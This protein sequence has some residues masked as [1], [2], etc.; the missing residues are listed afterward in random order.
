M[1]TSISSTDPPSVFAFASHDGHVRVTSAAELLQVGRIGKPHG[2]KGLVHVDLSTDRIE[3]LAVGTRLL[4]GDEWLTVASA[5]RHGTAWLVR[6]EGIDD[7]TA[8]E[9]IASRILRAEPIDDPDA[10]WVHELVGAPVRERD[11]TGRGR[12]VA[13]IANPAHDLLELD[14]GALV[15]VAFVVEVVDGTIVIDPPDGLFD[16]DS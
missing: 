10:L 16:L 11:G 12:C 7:R 5:A 6:F 4:A 9:G 2:L 15:P 3:R 1:S 13:V 14:S 8:A